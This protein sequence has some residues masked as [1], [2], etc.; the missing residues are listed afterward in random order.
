MDVLT[1]SEFRKRYASLTAPTKVTVNGHVIGEWRPL[2]DV[3][4]DERGEVTIYARHD[5][6]GKTARPA[7]DLERAALL[8]H[9]GSSYPEFRPAPKPGKR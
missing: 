7:T 1:S 9:L 6:R 3:V 8:P 5:P 2:V 4:G